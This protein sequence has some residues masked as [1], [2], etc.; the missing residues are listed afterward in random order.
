MDN[1]TLHDSAVT[2]DGPRGQGSKRKAEQNKI[3]V[4]LTPEGTQPTFSS[5]LKNEDVL[6]EAY[7]RD[8]FVQFIHQ[9]LLSGNSRYIVRLKRRYINKTNMEQQFYSYDM[10]P[11][12]FENLVPGFE[13]V[14]S[15][16]QYQKAI[17]LTRMMQ[18]QQKEIQDA[19][20]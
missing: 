5:N 19:M 1:Y 8:Y 20:Q 16:E 10:S 9:E 14:R 12:V 3:S 7:V 18:Q 13:L 11:Y 17:E 4:D 6:V 15:N 2:D